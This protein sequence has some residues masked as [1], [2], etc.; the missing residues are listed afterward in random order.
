L[1][2]TPI[3]GVQTGISSTNLDLELERY[4]ATPG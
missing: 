2:C 1:I 4:S 3:W